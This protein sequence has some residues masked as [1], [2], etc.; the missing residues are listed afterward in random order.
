MS[1]VATANSY[2]WSYPIIFGTI[3]KQMLVTLFSNSEHQKRC[4]SKARSKKHNFATQKWVAAQKSRFRTVPFPKLN[5]LDWPDR[6]LVSTWAAATVATSRRQNAS[7]APR[8]FIPRSTTSTTQHRTTGLE[9]TGIPWDRDRSALKVGKVWWR[10]L[11]A[12]ALTSER[13]SGAGAR[14]RL[15]TH[16]GRRPRGVASA[17]RHFCTILFIWGVL[18]GF[19]ILRLFYRVLL[20]IETMCTVSIQT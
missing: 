8:I 20:I 5:F 3:L 19:V 14:R 1:I 4:D 16:A 13:A 18:T 6:C 7:P 12:V 15:A 2:S 17:R 11:V 10:V 9:R